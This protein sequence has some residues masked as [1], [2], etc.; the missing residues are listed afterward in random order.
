MKKRKHIILYLVH[1]LH[2]AAVH[3]RVAMLTHAGANMT[4]VGFNRGD[5]KISL[6]HKQPVIDFGRTYNANFI[7]RI[8]SV[9]KQMAH[10]KKHKKAFQGSDAIIA[11]NLEMLAIAVYGRKKFKRNI[12]IIYESL[13]IHRLLLNDDII[14]KTLRALE[15]KLTQNV[16]RLWTSSPAFIENYFKRR[17]ELNLP[18]TLVENK[19]FDPSFT[20]N[21]SNKSPNDKPWKIGWF[22]A[23]RCAKSLN[24]LK[25]FTNQNNGSI[26]VIIRGKPAYDQFN[27]FD[28]IIEDA[29]FIHF[30]GPYKNPDDLEEIYGEIHFT[31]AIDMFEEGLNS[32]WLLPNRLYEGGLYNTVPIA[33]ENVETGKFIT[34]KNIGRTIKTASAKELQALFDGLNIDTYRNLKEKSNIIPE[35]TWLCTQ[36]ECTKLLESIYDRK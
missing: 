21:G 30:H 35:S 25:D 2:D 27:D 19:V 29:P 12:P 11:R 36:A 24:I 20:N 8:L 34:E 33:I 31:W 6:I 22:G 18:I 32:S 14:G 9:F 7:Q 3:K 4:I 5:S 15:K 1:D 10:I 17:T 28:Q 26:E 23:I 16:T 13:D